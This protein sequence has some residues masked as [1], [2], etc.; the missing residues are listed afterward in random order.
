[1]ALG[2]AAHA[3][4][5]LQEYGIYALTA[6]HTVEE[7]TYA[8]QISQKDAVNLLTSLELGKRFYGK[9]V[10]S[11]IQIRGVEDVYMH[12]RSMAT[13]PK[14]QLRALLINSRYQVVHEELLA[15]GSIESLHITPRDTFQAAVERRVNGII[16]VHNHPSGDPTPS[17]ADYDFTTATIEVGKVLGIQL[18]DHVIIAES[19][20]MSCI[21]DTQK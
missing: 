2:N 14:E 5:Y 13:L 12:Y 7:M 19:G 18:L 6:L 8:L 4:E 9:N 10:G 16:L 1:M 21:K 11:L 15:V 3:V 17:K 20:Y